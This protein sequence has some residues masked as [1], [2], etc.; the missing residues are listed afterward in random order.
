MFKKALLLLPI[1]SF[2]VAHSQNDGNHEMVSMV[3]LLA[4]PEKYDNKIVTIVGVG[5]LKF[6]E[7]QICLTR[8]HLRVM[9]T[10]NCF[11]L[12][13]FKREKWDAE[14]LMKIKE[15]NGSYVKVTGRFNSQDMGHL[16]LFAG[17]IS[18]VTACSFHEPEFG[19]SW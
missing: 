18:D 16:N 10:K 5:W 9:A 3:Q 1:F 2:G 7:N 6:E 15:F 19:P 4:N 14:L 11:W 17:S 8:D 12:G 13:S